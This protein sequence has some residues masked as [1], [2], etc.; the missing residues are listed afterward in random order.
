MSIKQSRMAAWMNAWGWLKKSG[1]KRG[2]EEKSILRVCP[3]GTLERND[4][5][6]WR[7]HGSAKDGKKKSV[8]RIEHSMERTRWVSST[9]TGKAWSRRKCQAQFRLRLRS[10]VTRLPHQD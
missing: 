9:S 10:L 6:R 2:K 5:G 7:C 8:K 3:N 1:R 4:N